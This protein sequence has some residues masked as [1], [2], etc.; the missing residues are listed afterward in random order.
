MKRN[1]FIV[2]IA[3]MFVFSMASISA[4][5]DGDDLQVDDEAEIIENVDESIESSEDNTIYISPD[6]SGDGLNSDNPTNWD[7]AYSKVN[8]G[9]TIIFNDGEYTNIVNKTINKE[10]TLKAQNRDSAILDGQNKNNFFTVNKTK[11]TLDGITFKNG[12]ATE[13]G[14]L[15]FT[16]E[17]LNSN[18]SHCKFI[19][20]VGL[21]G[22][23][24][25]FNST[26]NNNEFTS[27]FINCSNINRGAAIFCK[28]GSYNV[29]DGNYINCSSVFGGAIY[30]DAYGS[31]ANRNRFS[32]NFINCT[33]L[34]SGSGGAIYLYCFN[35]YT[36]FSGKFIN[37]AAG[38]DAGAIYLRYSYNSKFN[39]EFENCKSNKSWGGVMYTYRSV[40]DLF[41][42]KF[43]NCSAGIDGGVAGIYEQATNLTFLGDYINCSA[44]FGSICYADNGIINSTINVNAINC[45]GSYGTV[46]RLGGC[47][48]TIFKG[49]YTNCISNVQYG[50]GAITIN[51]PI[52]SNV[53]INGT[54]IN[55]FADYGPAVSLMG[56][57][58]LS[59][60]IYGTFINCTS[61]NIGTLS[62]Y[63]G[64]TF[65]SGKF[66]NCSADWG[67]A[68]VFSYTKNDDDPSYGNNTISGEF[69]NCYSKTGGIVDG[70]CI[71]I[72]N[73]IFKDNR[74]DNKSAIFLRHYGPGGK[75]I[76]DG[77]VNVTNCIL[78]NNKAP[79]VS[80]NIINV[81]KENDCE[82]TIVFKGTNTM[83]NAIYGHVN[84]KN[85]TYWG[86]NGLVNSED[87]ENT[88]EF[89]AIGQ[90]ITWQLL[91][92]NDNVVKSG[93]GITDNNG[94]LKLEFHDLIGNYTLKAIHYDDDYYTEI[95]NNLTLE[96][97]KLTPT[98]SNNVSTV[99][100][101]DD[102]VV[103]IKMQ[104]D[105]TGKLIATVNNTN[106]TFDVLNGEATLTIPAKML[107]NIYQVTALITFEGNDRYKSG[108]TTV[109]INIVQGQLTSPDNI[110]RGWN[111]GMDA[112]CALLDYS[113][114]LITGKEVSLIVNGKTYKATAGNDGLIRFNVKLP[115]GNYTATF[116]YNDQT[117]VCHTN[118]T[119]VKRLLENTDI[120]MDYADG[121]KYKVLAIG[122]DGQP[123]GAGE[124]VII[125]VNGKS[126]N[127][128][129]DKNGYAYLKINLKPKAYTITAE[130]KNTKV[131]NKLTVKQILKSNNVKVK[132]S[133]KKMVLKATLKSSKGKAISGKKI[134]F[135]KKKK[136]Y[137]A[138]TN[139]KGIAKVTIKKNLIKKLKKGKKYTVKIK[140]IKDSIKKTVKA[141]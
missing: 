72:E 46:F 118:I 82:I 114:N 13:G 5:Q 104:S 18:F 81:T 97:E 129:T 56:D 2:L 92:S 122:D 33:C 43:I 109:T 25:Y 100:K 41:D 91:D 115:V 133:A 7:D 51:G 75:Y 15:C 127:V 9:W 45:T 107:E 59:N 79:A 35:N 130:Y 116:Y 76:L 78:I 77:D 66:I 54:F 139:K 103:N 69:I 128:K 105:I 141:I 1:V 48:N 65:V 24:I 87:I 102:A 68:A 27:D 28:G 90:N 44:L 140:Y 20:C 124:T 37:C 57:A 60:H 70:N 23:A 42:G 137:K 3:F 135:K 31:Y 38:G 132:R 14:A 94:L 17:S 106:I 98:F 32:G 47:E 34:P 117:N 22:G 4:S 86:P 136:T 62:L 64:K 131:S 110:T 138:K 30:F 112:I 21:W 11:I 63:T 40:N 16:K 126:Y 58:N 67:G 39:G 49:N 74:V 96:F 108:N 93:V 29:F 71:R 8:D 99:L 134:T 121:T 73:A 55:C 19:N 120:T 101:G 6:G 95:S 85:V 50:N 123:V 10:L 83:L 26:I 89:Y 53:T 113:G 88:R 119:I 125:K 61:H 12:N 36:D 84:L 111:S 52:I 80:L